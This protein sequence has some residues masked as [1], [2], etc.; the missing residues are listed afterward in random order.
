MPVTMGI[1]NRKGVPPTLTD[2]HRLALGIELRYATFAA[3]GKNKESSNKKTGS[4]EPILTNRLAPFYSAIWY[5]FPRHL[6]AVLHSLKQ[7]LLSHISNMD[8]QLGDFI[9]HNRVK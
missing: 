7:W 5:P 2:W 4:R 8:R 1:R 3:Q 6:Q 9:S